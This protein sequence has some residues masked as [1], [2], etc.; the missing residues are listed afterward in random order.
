M[1]TTCAC[2]WRETTANAS[3]MQRMQIM[4]I[5]KI[6]LG[7]FNNNMDQTT[8]FMSFLLLFTIAALF[9]SVNNSKPFEMFTDIM[10]NSNP[11]FTFDNISV[12]MI[13]L[14]RNTDRLESFIEQY[15]MSDLRYKQFQRISAV[16]GTS[17]NVKEEVSPGAFDEITQIEKTGYRTKH[18]QLTRGAIGCYLSHVKA[19]D[20]ISAGDADYGFI[21]ED[22]ANIDPML[23]AKLNKIVGTMD[24][25]W[26]MLLLGCH[27]IICEKRDTY[28]DLE[29]FFL[30]HGYI[31]KKE[32]AQK[33]ST[34]LKAKKISQQVDSEISDMIT[35][36]HFKVYCLKNSLS[37]QKGFETNIQTP[38]KVMPGVNPYTTLI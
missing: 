7:R 21:F 33:L 23:L 32:A 19:Y 6:I 14:D 12:Y 30:M 34:M 8:T 3:K 22:D 26:D 25:T 27:C 2:V 20:F 5:H 38:L 29:K 24:D 17:L 15:M 13:N 10:S 35:Q 1:H 9:L 11:K 4:R 16:D 18:Y 37:T 31:V 36:G 28:Y